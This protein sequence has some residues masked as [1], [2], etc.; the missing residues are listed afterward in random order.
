M[1]LL[2][3]LDW[4]GDGGQ[5]L[6]QATVLPRCVVWDYDYL[7]GHLRSDDEAPLLLIFLRRGSDI[8]GE[9]AGR[10][11]AAGGAGASINYC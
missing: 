2:L 1:L 7:A 9:M 6:R 11:P 10:L 5:G 3:R 4:R 8:I